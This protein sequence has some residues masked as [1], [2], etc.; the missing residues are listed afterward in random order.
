MA[1]NCGCSRWGVVCTFGLGLTRVDLHS[2]LSVARVIRSKKLHGG[3]GMF[4]GI[5]ALRWVCR[6]A[7]HIPGTAH[8]HGRS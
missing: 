8:G 7:G 5:F 1:E 2:K 6:V 4:G 3:L